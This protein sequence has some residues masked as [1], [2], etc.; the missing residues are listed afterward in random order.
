MVSCCRHMGAGDWLPASPRENVR[1]LCV[2]ECSDFDGVPEG[3]GTL[4]TVFVT[5]CLAMTE[6]WLPSSSSQ[7]AYVQTLAI[8][9]NRISIVRLP[10]NMR[11]CRTSCGCHVVLLAR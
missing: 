9:A 4:Q 3:M 2:S 5:E 11:P 10:A 7:H 1:S 8:D 6:G